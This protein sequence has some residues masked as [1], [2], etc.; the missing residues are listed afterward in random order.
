M[1][2]AVT[3]DAGSVTGVLTSGATTDDTSLVLSGTNEAGSTV[4][5]FNG[6]TSLGQATVSGTSW[7]Y[8]ATVED[9]T[10]YQFNVKETDAAG[11]ISDA[12]SNFTVTGDT[13]APGFTSGTPAA[14]DENGSANALVYT[15]TAT[16]A[17]TVAYSL[18]GTDASA[19]TIDATTGAVTIN[20]PAD[21][22]TKTS[23][24]F[25]VVATDLAGNSTTHAVTLAVNDLDD[26]PTVTIA[27]SDLSFKSDGPFHTSVLD[28]N[29]D[30]IMELIVAEYR[31]NKFTLYQ[32]KDGVY[33][34]S[35]S[36][37]GPRAHHTSLTDFNKDGYMDIVSSAYDQTK[38]YSLIMN[39]GASNIN[40][41]FNF[42]N[43]LVPGSAGTSSGAVHTSVADFNN[44]LYPDIIGSSYTSEKFVLFINDQNGGFAQTITINNTDI[45]QVA[46]T[47]VGDIDKDGDMDIVAVSQD[48][49]VIVFMN[50]GTIDSP[51][52]D[53]GTVIS[54]T[55]GVTTHV[56]LAHLNSDEYLDMIVAGISG[57]FYVFMN[58]G[59]GGFELGT[60]I[61]TPGFSDALNTTVLDI[62]E[63]GDQDILGSTKSGD[64]ILITNNGTANVFNF[65]TVEQ[66]GQ[67]SGAATTTV[68]D[69]DG[70]G[71]L[72]ILASS[73]GSDWVYV[74]DI[75]VT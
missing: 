30:N 58:D 17:S 51:V 46:S 71:S 20:A 23:Y 49:M 56:N 31:G 52:F 7:S 14:I 57:G 34:E 25:D 70:D 19:F 60:M 74:Y 73:R 4:E 22:E 3:D 27:L 53:G 42:D 18:A 48:S 39:T 21:Y 50:T 8:T 69:I 66:Y 26:T 6:A 36:F 43:N 9:G 63:D 12:T 45:S 38:G 33:E 2:S 29:N 75:T 59:S 40:D 72:E 54:T 13:T 67:G 68:A 62:D 35:H 47:S 28:A 10:T 65:N 5:V 37:D 1:L 55:P 24:S 16:D 11:N 64:F 32:S 44:D 41:S 61:N 15:A